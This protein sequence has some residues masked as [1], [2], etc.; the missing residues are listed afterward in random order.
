MRQFSRSTITIIVTP[1]IDRPGYFI[2]TL[3]GAELCQSTEPLLAAARELVQRG[4]PADTVLAMRHAGADYDALRSTIGAAAAL[5]VEDGRDGTPR[6]RRWKA[7]PRVGQT[8]PM[9]SGEPVAIP[10]G[11]GQFAGV[12]ARGR[13]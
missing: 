3:S 7:P 2:A 13:R 8:P 4:A 12:L 10:Q 1:V 6:F 9:R 11:S 5:T